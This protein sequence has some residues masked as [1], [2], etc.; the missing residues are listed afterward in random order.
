MNLPNKLTL[1]RMIATPVFMATMMFSAIPYN[2]TISLVIFIL[3]SITDYLDGKIARK[4][5]LVTNFGKFSD[6]IADKMLTTAA[7]LG[8]MII[9]PN[10]SFTIQ[11]TIFVFITLFREFTVASVRL[12]AA[13]SNSRKVIAA[14][15]WGKL[16]T[17]SQMVSIILGLLAYSV[18]ELVTGCDMASHILL[19]A[20]IVTGW[21]SV[22]FTI[23][24]GVIYLYESK[25]LIDF[26]K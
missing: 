19:I 17:V 2:Y 23:I 25:E 6:P 10:R 15:I 21:I 14:N 4:Y 3:A 22:A 11:V 26:T 8:F 20:F 13:A 18:K 24:S 16:K 5:G 12:V 7:L 9:M 1:A